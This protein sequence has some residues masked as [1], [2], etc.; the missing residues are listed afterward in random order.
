MRAS[1]TFGD[2]IPALILCGRGRVPGL[3]AT[4]IFAVPSP[5]RLTQLGI[6]ST[7]RALIAAGAAL[8]LRHISEPTRPY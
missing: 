2:R 4:V 8:P 6:S 3:I 5:I 1:P 7:P